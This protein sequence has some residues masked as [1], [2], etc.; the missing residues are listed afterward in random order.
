MAIVIIALIV[1]LLVLLL[2]P[3]LWVKRIVRRYQTPA[4]RYP[5]SGAQFA[6]HLLD[7]LELQQVAVEE[8]TGGDHYDPVAKVVRL[9]PPHFQ[10][11]S[12]SAI[13]VAAHEVGHAMQDRDDYK[14]LRLRHRL[15]GVATVLQ[16]VGS[17]LLLLSPLILL[18]SRSPL[19]G[20]VLLLAG[21]FVMALP[22]VMTMITL[23]VEW[24]ASFSRA[25]PMLKQGGY[26]LPGDEKAANRLLK[27]AA[28]TYVAAALESLLNVSRWLAVLLRR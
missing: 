13:V 12:L 6:R 23:P 5:G 9:T 11:N 27:A 4:D 20:A 24:N 3:Q 17:A 15:V 1:A 2:G 16:Q 22:V 19:A 7:Q 21:F 8:T 25:M 14:P 10:Q 28:M 26:L 18:G